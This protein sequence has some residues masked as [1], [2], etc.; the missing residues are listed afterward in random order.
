MPI[1]NCCYTTFL[2]VKDF[3]SLFLGKGVIFGGFLFS[4]FLLFFYFLIFRFGGRAPFPLPHNR[5]VFLLGVPK[6]GQFQH[7]KYDRTEPGRGE[8]VAII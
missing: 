7:A 1:F 2:P 8:T 3:I 5:I 4:F 6:I